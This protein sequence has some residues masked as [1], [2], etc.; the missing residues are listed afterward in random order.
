VLVGA[1]VAHTGAG[2]AGAPSKSVTA[3]ANR[4]T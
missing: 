1:D 2:R 4:V 3:A